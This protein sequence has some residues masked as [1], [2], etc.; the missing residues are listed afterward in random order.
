MESK[1]IIVKSNHLIEAKYKLSMREQK[2][3]LYLI[4]KIEKNDD[5]LK[6]YRISV[7][8]FNEMMGLK[9]SPKYSEIRE[10]TTELLK[11]VLEVKQGKTIYSFHWLSLVAYNEQEG[12]IDMRFDPI[13][14]P[15]LLDLKR[16]FTKLNLKHILLLK[17]GNSIRI[18]ELLKQ[19]LNIRERTIK[20]TDLKLFLGLDENGYQMYSDFKRKVIVPSMKEINEKTDISFDFKEIKE[21]RKV[22]SLRF[23]IQSKSLGKQEIISVEEALDD[24]LL[25]ELKV[26]LDKKGYDLQNK[27][28]KKWLDAAN[29]IWNEASATELVLLVKD[30]VKKSTIENHLAFITYILNEKVKHIESGKD[31]RQITV[32]DNYK[33][34]IRTEL[35]PSWFIEQKENEQQ[36]LTFED[37]DEEFLKKKAKLQAELKARKEKAN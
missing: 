17:S 21:G 14:K 13:L 16:D 1:E 26:L 19:Y 2:I 22:I 27:I 7:K 4:S 5:D 3:I 20:I 30:S 35:L 31:H 33:N 9:G 15:Y 36:E 32:Q 28:Y 23:F 12:T 24:P 10:I 11:K 29:K 8:N 37:N 25:H 6:L 34:T 18:Y